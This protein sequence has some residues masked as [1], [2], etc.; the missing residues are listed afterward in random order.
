MS[1]KIETEQSITLKAVRPGKSTINMVPTSAP[2]KNNRSM[3]FVI[4][5]AYLLS[6]NW[7]ACIESA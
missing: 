6:F 2:V 4:L 7:S 3:L 5:M 1:A